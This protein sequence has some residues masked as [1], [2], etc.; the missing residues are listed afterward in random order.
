MREI[1]RGT[2]RE[3]VREEWKMHHVFTWNSQARLEITKESGL[4][5]A[6]A[7]AKHRGDDGSSMCHTSID[8]KCFYHTYMF[9]TVFGYVYMVA[10]GGVVLGPSTSFGLPSLVSLKGP[11]SLL[12]RKE[13]TTCVA[14]RTRRKKVGHRLRVVYK[15]VPSRW[16]TSFNFSRIAINP[17]LAE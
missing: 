7:R 8:G 9:W 11:V 6:V 16:S 15:V 4:V 2:K 13:S 17:R 12:K 14:R 3:K 10:G 5:E 1:E